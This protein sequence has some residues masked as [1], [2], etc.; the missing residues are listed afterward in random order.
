MKRWIYILMVLAGIYGMQLGF[1]KISNTMEWK[2]VKTNQPIETVVSEIFRENQV[3]SQDCMI[4][5]FYFYDICFLGD[6]EK[7]AILQQVVHGLGISEPDT[8]EKKQTSQGGETIVKIQGESCQA[9]IK[10]ITY[11]I[12]EGEHTVSLRQYIRVELKICDSIPRGFYYK[13]KLEQVLT[14][15]IGGKRRNVPDDGKESR[16]RLLSISIMGKMRGNVGLDIQEEL[17]RQILKSMEAKEIFSHK[18]EEK[19]EGC[20]NIYGYTSRI[21]EALVLG[22]KKIN[23]NVAYHYEEQENITVIHVA[24]PI[25]NY[26]Y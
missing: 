3:Q 25:V 10:L 9:V 18:P 26:D 22:E 2:Q 20:F 13:E 23:V 19:T 12:P 17:A 7:K 1:D 16:D 4:E 11:E 5:A 15:L 14:E 24:S 21:E 8:Y 6:D